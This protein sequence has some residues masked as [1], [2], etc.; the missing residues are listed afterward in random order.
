MLRTIF[1]AFLVSVVFTGE[2]RAY[3]DPGTGSAI[4]QM[5]LAGL[6]GALFVLKTYW[7]SL[8]AYFSGKPPEPVE[9]PSPPAGQPNEHD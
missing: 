6:M 4:L 3:L 2:A 9:P 7:R 1:T 8:I 5:T